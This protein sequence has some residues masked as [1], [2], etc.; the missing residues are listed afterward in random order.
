MI[1]STEVKHNGPK[2]ILVG[3]S[4][5]TEAKRT[6]SRTRREEEL[7]VIQPVMI[8]KRIIGMLIK[9]IGMLIRIRVRS[10]IRVPPPPNNLYRSRARL[11]VVQLNQVQ[12]LLLQSS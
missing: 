8:G 1:P 5:S 7:G 10:R 4:N 9:M 6:I 3:G 2:P 11:K 12:R